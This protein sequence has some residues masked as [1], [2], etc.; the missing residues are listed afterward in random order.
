LN[1]TAQRQRIQPRGLALQLDGRE[2]PQQTAED[3][4]G[5]EPGQGC[6]Q[7]DMDPAAE[8]QRPA[9]GPGDVEAVRVGEAVGVVVPGAQ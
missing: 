7:A 5:L 1:G 4:L 9:L 6:A 2:P 8:G 3:D